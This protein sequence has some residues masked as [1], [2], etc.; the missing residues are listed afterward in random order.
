[1]GHL[2]RDLILIIDQQLRKALFLHQM[3]LGI[4]KKNYLKT[5]QQLR[6]ALFLLQ[7][8]QEFGQNEECVAK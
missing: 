1:M 4:R 6:K 5:D 3:C 8:C 2:S 7:M